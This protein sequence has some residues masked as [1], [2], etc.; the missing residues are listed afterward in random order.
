MK[1][2]FMGTAAAE[3]VP[4][5]FCPCDMCRYARS[6][7]GRELRTRSGALIDGKIKLDMPPDSFGQAVRLG[8]DMSGLQ[9]VFITHSHGDHVWERDLLLDGSVLKNRRQRGL[10]LN[11]YG[12]AAVINKLRGIMP[13]E[14]EMQPL[15]K[16]TPFL[17]VE[18]A[19]YRVTPLKAVHT[20]IS[21]GVYSEDALIFLI[22]REGKRILYA[23]DTDVFAPETMEAIAGAGIDLIS[24]DC[25]N[26]R[27]DLD[28]IGHMGI[29]NNIDLREKLLACGAARPDTV[30]VA[31][32]FS[33]NGLLPYGE[34]C[35]MAPGFIISY[36]GMEIEV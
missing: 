19:G 25:T 13:N 20:Y 32:H 12:N 29:K 11:V 33:H 15:T 2:V 35:D 10:P 24:L 22:E 34:M 14:S 27:L 21:P 30:F 5:P 26:G 1:I 31:N 16:L 18:A 17:P 36:D 9:H 23:H 4:A 6:A 8:I 28:Y 7:G 3:G